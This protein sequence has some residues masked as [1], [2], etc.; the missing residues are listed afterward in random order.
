M[1]KI[2]LLILATFLLIVACGKDDEVNNPIETNNFPFLKIGHSWTYLRYQNN[3][4]D[5]SYRTSI[6]KYKVDTTINSINCCFYYAGPP[7]QNIYD[8]DV[9]FVD[10]DSCVFEAE[11]GYPWFWQTYTV[12]K[13][14]YNSLDSAMVMEVVSIN[15]SVTVEAGTFNNCIKIKE[16]YAN[17][18]EDFIWIR[19]DIGF[20]KIEREY[21]DFGMELK[22]KNF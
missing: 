3:K 18:R 4:T 19:N 16:F 13:K 17:N 11:K 20:I 10:L 8:S 6:L 1:R 21:D 9:L 22:S 12:G 14:Y 15:E 2:T 7:S 5:S